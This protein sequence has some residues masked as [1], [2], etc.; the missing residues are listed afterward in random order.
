MVSIQS[1]A[2]ASL[3]EQM[4]Y[5]TSH[6]TLTALQAIM[7]GIRMNLAA[8]LTENGGTYADKAGLFVAQGGW[9]KAFV[10]SRRTK[11]QLRESIRAIVNAI[12]QDVG[13]MRQVKRLAKHAVVAAARSGR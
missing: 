11:T 1:D 3:L 9:R 6:E 7:Y 13:L 2:A 10:T 12:L 5:D 8:V 4:K